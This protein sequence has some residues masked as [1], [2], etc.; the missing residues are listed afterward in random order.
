MHDVGNAAVAQEAHYADAH[1]Y[2]SFAVTGPA[3]LAV[4][5]LVVSDT[6]TL[7]ADANDDK[8]TITS[9]SSRG[10]GKLFTYDSQTDTVSGD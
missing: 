3:I 7:K 6:I 8:Y 9:K 1:T 10:T 2:V 5:G 4:P